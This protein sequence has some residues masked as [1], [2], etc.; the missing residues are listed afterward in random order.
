MEIRLCRYATGMYI[1]FDP[2]HL[3]TDIRSQVVYN[4]YISTNNS[5]R[6]N[7]S[8]NSSPG[9]LNS[10][11]IKP[12]N[13]STYWK[14]NELVQT[15]F[16]THFT[17]KQ[18][19]PHNPLKKNRQKS[20]NI[21]HKRAFQKTPRTKLESLHTRASLQKNCPHSSPRAD[22]NR[23]HTA[24]RYQTG[25]IPG[26]PQ[27]KRGCAPDYGIN[28]QMRPAAAF[29]L[30]FCLAC[31]RAHRGSANGI[32]GA[33]VGRG[34]DRPMGR[35]R[36]L[37]AGYSAHTRAESGRPRL[38]CGEWE[39][40]EVVVSFIELDRC[41]SRRGFF[42]RGISQFAWVGLYFLRNLEIVKICD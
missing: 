10:M 4:F 5:Y 34:L 25:R 37:E 19:Q 39:P 3:T 15:F 28:K 36:A 14:K 33:A 23:V 29:S 21:K 18:R 35:P 24:Q 2:L 11:F 9:L 8:G 32:E 27:D 12:I 6:Q 13:R 22:H 1:A 26:L 40:R 17:S 31:A 7:G 38:D 16:S 42:S 30:S 20:F 41:D